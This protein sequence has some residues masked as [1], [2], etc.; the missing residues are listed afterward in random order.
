MTNFNA[1]FVKH[2]CSLKDGAIL[3]RFRMKD[4]QN[5]ADIIA[6]HQPTGILFFSSTIFL[7]VFMSTCPILFVS[8]C[9]ISGW[10]CSIILTFLNRG[11]KTDFIIQEI[12]IPIFLKGYSLVFVLNS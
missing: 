7:N 9:I 3:G 8:K 4:H 1:T 12:I 10:I 2:P 11:H 5:M 6:L